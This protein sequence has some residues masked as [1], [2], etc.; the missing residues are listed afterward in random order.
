MV[1][2]FWIFPLTAAAGCFDNPMWR[3]QPLTSE[4]LASIP[5]TE[6]TRVWRAHLAVVSMR[7]DLK[8]PAFQDILTRLGRV[9]LMQEKDR[10]ARTK[11]RVSLKTAPPID[12]LN[13]LTLEALDGRSYNWVTELFW[14]LGCTDE[15]IERLMQTD[16]V[17]LWQVYFPLATDDPDAFR[18]LVER[19][20]N[21]DPYGSTSR[22]QLFADLLKQPGLAI[23]LVSAYQQSLSGQVDPGKPQPS[24][25]NQLWVANAV[26]SI[27]K[28][29]NARW[30]PRFDPAWTADTV[31]RARNAYISLAGMVLMATGCRSDILTAALSLLDTPETR[32][33]TTV[34]LPDDQIARTMLQPVVIRCLVA[35]G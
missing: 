35:A 18:Q 14:R 28:A 21:E 26:L 3:G 32:L 34:N 33:T 13:A 9:A 24:L 6:E 22:V 29:P 5:D 15:A 25:Q 23:E 31:V 10:D 30:V 7:E 17:W 19:M 11:L 4:F 12:V 27:L 2:L 16:Y 20:Q 1:F 8:S